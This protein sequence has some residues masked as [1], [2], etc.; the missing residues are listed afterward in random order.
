MQDANAQIGCF[1]IGSLVFVGNGSKA[2]MITRLEREVAPRDNCH[3]IPARAYFGSSVG[4]HL[5]TLSLA[6]PDGRG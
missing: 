5:N 6:G 2:R 1:K 3:G 4:H